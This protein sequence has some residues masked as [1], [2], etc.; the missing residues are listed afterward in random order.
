MVMGR[1]SMR[2]KTIMVTTEAVPVC[3]TSGTL[4]RTQ[5][6]DVAVESLQVGDLVMSVTGQARPILWIGHRTIDCQ[7]RPRLHEVLPVRIAANAMSEGRPSRDLRVSPGH[8]ICID[9]VGEVL[10]PAAALING[11]TIVQE[12]V[13]IVTYWHIELDSH[14]IILA[15]NMPCES[16]LNTGNRTFFAEGEAITLHA[17]PDVATIDHADSVAPSIRMGLWSL[18]FATVFRPVFQGWVGNSSRH[19]SRICT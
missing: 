1:C 12:R 2:S 6:G 4:I 14:D 18:L 8:A 17:S 19:P 3:F 13:D 16:H 11:T 15:E 10:I 7:R 9:A 5:R